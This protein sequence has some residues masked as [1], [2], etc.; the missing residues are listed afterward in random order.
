MTKS[1]HEL[2]K[3]ADKLSYLYVEHAVIDQHEKAIAVHQADGTTPVP[4][5][6]L[7]VLILGPGTSITH[8]AVRSLADNNCQV[9]WS[10]EHGVRFYAHGLGGARHSRNLIRQARLVSNDLTRLQ[11]VIRMYCLRFEEPVDPNIT[12]QQLRGKEG[13]RVRQAYAEAAKTF[14]VSWQ[15]R[16]YDRSAWSASDPVNRALS[17]ANA[18]LYGLVHAAS[19]SAGYSPA[20][21]FIHTGKQLSF[22]YDIADLY[23]AK[24]TVPVA[25]GVVKGATDIERQVRIACRDTF[26]Q[27]RLMERI[28]PDIQKILDVPEEAEQAVPDEF[29][30]DAARP[31]GLW[32]PEGIPLE[33]PI[34]EILKLKPAVLAFPK[35]VA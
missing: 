35:G 13:V 17:A 19:V 20:L 5:A 11:V 4:A 21:G 26:R 22:V 3:F 16:S 31:A 10:G 32:Q 6:G 24:Y 34:G 14:G 28:L 30:E 9:I 15:G 23:K 29:A 33:T 12:L 2:P 1:L 7:A 25:F 8:A 18:C 27:A